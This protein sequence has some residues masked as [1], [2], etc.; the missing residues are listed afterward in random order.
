MD[1]SDTTVIIPVMNE[2]AAGKVA[3]DAL[4]RLSKA[5]II[6]IYRGD[7]KVLGINSK[8]SRL[9]IIEQK[10]SGK[11]FAVVQAAKLVRTKIFCLIDGDA[12]YDVSD[13]KM[14]IERVREGAAM[15]MGD[16][17]RNLKREAMPLMIEFGNRVITIV[18]DL[19]Y[20]MRIE[21]SQTG[22]RA[23]KTE[24]FR[25]LDLHEQ[26]FGIESEMTIK[27]KKAGLQIDELP[28]NYY[29]RIGET[30]QMKLTGGIKLLLLNFK[31]L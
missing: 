21:D 20:G 4:A 10:G 14:V 17:L 26:Y 18:A 31:F 8:N 5:K 23:V 29:V 15:A 25:S 16:R 2:P 7:R 11:G 22:L 27:I 13:L 6:V 1:Y 9:R 19:L 12:T 3:A 30:K 24:V 28:I